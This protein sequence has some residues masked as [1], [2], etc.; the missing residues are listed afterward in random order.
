[1]TALSWDRQQG[2]ASGYDVIELGFNYRIDEPRAALASARLARLDGT[3]SDGRGPS[4]AYRAM[5]EDVDGVPPDTARRARPGRSN[6]LFTVVL[7]EALDRAR[8]RGKLE[9]DGVQ[10][11]LHYPAGPPLQHLRRGLSLPLTEAYGARA[12]TLP[13]FPTITEEQIGIVT[14]ALR[15]A[16]A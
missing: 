2:H 14:D 9:E 10:T 11:S 13:L 4:G 15:G 12:M 8:V 7:D 3:T 5:L 1:M 16:V 6:H